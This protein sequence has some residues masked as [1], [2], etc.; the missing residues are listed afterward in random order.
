MHRY[1]HLVLLLLIV[2]GWSFPA[3]A[4]PSADDAKVEAKADEKA[5]DAKAD[6]DKTEDAKED[7]KADEK[8]V[9]ETDGT[10]GT[11]DGK[12]E[13]KEIETDEEAVEAAQ[14]AYNALA[15]RNWAL[16][17]SFGLMLLV[18][19]LRKV[20]VLS[21]VPAK[22]VPWVTAVLGMA[23]YVAAALMTPGVSIGS[24]LL[25][26]AAAGAAAVGLWEMVLKHALG[27]K[28][29]DKGGGESS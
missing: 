24:A 19:I 5:D 16:G 12:A 25:E 15:N 20:K 14:G 11:D 22:A 18:F 27:N 2:F 21:K 8:A 23:G 9:R 1:T 17:I 3:V 10:D 6:E 26:G 13:S 7:A 29:K 28:G 4:Q